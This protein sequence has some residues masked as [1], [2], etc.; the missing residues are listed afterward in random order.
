MK[1]HGFTHVLN[2]CEGDDSFH[3][4]TGQEYYGAQAVY[5]GVP[6]DDCTVYDITQDFA[7]CNAFLHT[8]VAPS[9]DRSTH[10]TPRNNSKVMVHCKAGASRSAMVVLAYLV[11]YSQ[12]HSM[13][14][15]APFFQTG[16][17]AG[18]KMS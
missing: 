2:T 18:A 10:T 1:E 5:A 14:N 4:T 9:G 7:A 17:Q 13:P 16:A 6:A 3:V 12:S 15:I 11:K 8:V